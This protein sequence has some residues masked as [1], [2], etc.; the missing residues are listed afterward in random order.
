M[1]FGTAKDQIRETGINNFVGLRFWR[2]GGIASPL[3]DVATGSSQTR[4]A[5]PPGRLVV[6]ST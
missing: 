5:L 2:C 4:P 1:I 3:I 6:T